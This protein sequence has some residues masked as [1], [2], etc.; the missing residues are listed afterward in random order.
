MNLYV[1]VPFSVD[2]KHFGKNG[3]R[4][5]LRRTDEHLAAREHVLVTEK[6]FTLAVNGFDLALGFHVK[7]TVFG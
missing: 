5:V 2:G 7:L 6:L 4:A 3:V 1:R